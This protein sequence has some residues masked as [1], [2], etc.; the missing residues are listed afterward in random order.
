MH[1]RQFE[2]AGPFFSFAC[3]SLFGWAALLFGSRRLFLDRGRTILVFGKSGPLD[4]GPILM[5]TKKG[6]R[7][8]LGPTRE[9][10]TRVF[11]LEIT[12]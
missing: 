12:V 6:R 2:L 7:P 1:E 11:R 10:F 9:G 5:K 4:R 8:F 3:F